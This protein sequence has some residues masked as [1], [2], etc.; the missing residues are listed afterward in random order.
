MAKVK[1]SVD[2]STHNYSDKEL[3]IQGQTVGDN[4]NDNL[5]YSSLKELAAAIKVASVI[6]LGFLANMATGNK[7]L[8]AEK[9]VARINLEDLLGT[10]A[11]KVQDLS[12]G[13]EV[14]ILSSGFEINRKPTPVGILNQVLNV[15]AKLGKVAGSLDISW[16]VVNNAYSYEI[17]YTKNPKTDAS[18]YTNVTSTKRKVTIENLILGQTNIIQVAGVGSDPK[19]VWSVEVITCYVS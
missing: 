3:A 14:K 19:R 12:G 1:V 15:Q 16:D 17:R 18:V 5:N 7:Q 13:D 11:L 6:L 4:L 10:A 9:N 8:T 2:F